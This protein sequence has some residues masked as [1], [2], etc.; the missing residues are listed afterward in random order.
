MD[1]P[2]EF[3]NEIWPSIRDNLPRGKK[4]NALNDIK[5]KIRRIEDSATIK[6]IVWEI[7]E[8]YFGPDVIN[9]R[10]KKTANKKI[11]KLFQVEDK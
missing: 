5:N 11:D 2:K 4:T 1:V 8:Q 7:I 9:K 10:I 3:E 6:N